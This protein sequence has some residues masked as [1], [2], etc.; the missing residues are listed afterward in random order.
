MVKTRV[1]VDSNGHQ[2]NAKK[3]VLKLQ[4]T[5]CKKRFFYI[6]TYNITLSSPGH[7][8]FKNN[9]CIFTRATLC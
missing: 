2:K 4:K 8:S 6:S 5:Q 3:D 9:E 1:N 7:N